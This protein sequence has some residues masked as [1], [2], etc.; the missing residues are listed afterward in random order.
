MLAEPLIKMQT[1]ATA[2]VL[3][4]VTGLLNEDDE[5]EEEV[6]AKEILAP[7][8]K[9]LLQALVALLQ[10]GIQQNYEPLQTE[11]LQ[12]LSSVAQVLLEEFSVYYNDFIPLMQ[13]ILEKVGQTTMSEKQLRAKAIDSIGSIIIAVT[14]SDQKDEFKASVSSIAEYLSKLIQSGLTDDDP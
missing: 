12:L 3:S 6:D 8:S 5:A 9:Q 1:Q 13:E 7:Y 10:K 4:F 11:A 14:D 2:T